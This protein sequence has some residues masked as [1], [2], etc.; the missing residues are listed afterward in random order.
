[1][2]QWV[3]IIFLIVEYVMKIIAIGVVPENRRP[4]SSSAWLLLILFLPVV[5]FPL[6]WLIG[7][8]WVR[9]RRLAI[10]RQSDEIIK[11]HTVGLPDV[12]EG[13]R[14]P[15]RWRASSG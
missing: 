12:P 11:N 15:P 1:M 5:G 8:P 7:S 2:P 13:P 6:Y 9:G 4:S 10:Q 14:P 3:T